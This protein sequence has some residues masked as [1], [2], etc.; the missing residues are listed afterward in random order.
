[1]LNIE[2]HYILDEQQ[3]AIAVQIPIADYEKIE[4]IL[5]NYG[6]VQLM[7]SSDDKERLSRDAAMQFY[8]DL[9]NGTV[10]D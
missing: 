4:E 9:K 6:L 7:E 2:K 1:M 8:Q 3:R 10:A 5:E